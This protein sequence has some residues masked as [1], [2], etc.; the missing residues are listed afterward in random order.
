MIKL[1]SICF[2]WILQL[3]TEA[4]ASAQMTCTDAEGISRGLEYSKKYPFPVSVA[5][6]TEMILVVTAE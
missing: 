1:Q 2:A 3:L 5:E 4:A 6:S